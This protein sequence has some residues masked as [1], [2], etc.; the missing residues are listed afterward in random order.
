MEVNCHKC[1]YGASAECVPRSQEMGWP[2][3]WRNTV[4]NA[5][6]LRS[7]SDEEL[8]D[9]LDWLMPDKCPPTFKSV[10]APE[11][12]YENGC[13]DCWLAWLK[14]ETDDWRE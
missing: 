3:C 1:K 11:C 5:D 14:R 8:A 13:R 6:R 4:T 2:K 10:F 7:K 12:T 9:W